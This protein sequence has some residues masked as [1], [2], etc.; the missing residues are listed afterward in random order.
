M[1]QLGPQVLLSTMSGFPVSLIKVPTPGTELSIQ[2]ITCAVQLHFLCMG[3]L[4]LHELYGPSQ[5]KP[6]CGSVIYILRGVTTTSPF[7]W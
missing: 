6:P 3:E 1:N 2:P 7:R 4:E 5:P